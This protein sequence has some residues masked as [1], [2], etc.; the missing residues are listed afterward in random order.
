MTKRENANVQNLKQSSSNVT[1]GAGNLTG[2]PADPAREMTEEGIGNGR[3]GDGNGDDGDDVPQDA[4]A[5]DRGDRDDEDARLRRDTGVFAV[6]GA[7]SF[8]SSLTPVRGGS[9]SGSDPSPA[10]GGDG[11][12]A[13]PRDHP[14]DRRS[15]ICGDWSLDTLRDEVERRVR[16][17]DGVMSEAIAVAL[18][19]DDDG[20]GRGG[21]GGGGPDLDWAGGSSSSDEIEATC[22][23]LAG[24][25][26]CPTDASMSG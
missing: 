11:P 25:G 4:D 16:D 21:G 12:S 19:E 23:Y 24:M 13:P 2:R 17:V 3:D 20:G 1:V 15:T 6:A 18:L 7:S 14:A 8:G 22:L 9:S 26:G 10:A 5:S